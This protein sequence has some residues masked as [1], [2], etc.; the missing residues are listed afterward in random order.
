MVVGGGNL[1]RV[2]HITDHHYGSFDIVHFKDAVG[3]TKDAVGNTTDAVATQ[4]AWRSTDWTLGLDLAWRSIFQETSQNLT[5]GSRRPSAAPH[6][7]RE[8][9]PLIRFLKNRLKYAL[10]HEEVKKIVIQRLILVDGIVRTDLTITTGFMGRSLP[11]LLWILM[12]TRSTRDCTWSG[13]RVEVSRLI[14]VHLFQT[15]LQLR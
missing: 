11:S 7:L 9:L 5:F 13:I 1:I 4:G 12:H 8:Y 6:R 2:G 14:L 15:L 10:S 3:N